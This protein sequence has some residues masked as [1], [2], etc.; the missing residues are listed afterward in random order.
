MKKFLATALLL[1]FCSPVV[2][3]EATFRRAE[4]FSDVHA[5]SCRVR[6]RSSLG[7][8]TFVGFTDGAGWIFTNYHVVGKETDVKLDFWTNSKL[9]TLEGKV[10]W[11]FYNVDLP[12]DFAFV[13]VDTNAL[14]R[15]DP[16]FVP[17][18]GPDV[19]PTKNG[20]I[21]SSGCPD[22]RFAQAWRGEVVSYYNGKT[23]VFQ[24]PPVPG[25]SGSGIVEYID[26]KPYVVAILTWLFGQKGSDE[27]TGGAIPV[28]N[29]YLAADG[30]V[31]L[32]MGTGGFDAI[33]PDATECTEKTPVLRGADEAG[34]LVIVVFKQLNC[35]YCVLYETELKEIEERGA[36]VVRI[37]RDTELGRTQFQ[38]W[39]VKTSPSTFVAAETKPAFYVRRKRLKDG[40]VPSGELEREL[41]IARDAIY[42]KALPLE[43]DVP[44]VAASFERDSNS[45]ES[46]DIVVINNDFEIAEIEDQE[47]E[48]EDFS[49]EPEI[50]EESSISEID[51]E[52]FRKR[53]PVHESGM[54]LG[55]LDKSKEDWKNR[56]SLPR[57]EETPLEEERPT[58]KAEKSKKDSDS[59]G[60]T[61]RL[62]DSIVDGALKSID[63]KLS[64]KQDEIRTQFELLQDKVL[65]SLFVL[66]IISFMTATIVLRVV[67]AVLRWIGRRVSPI[68]VAFRRAMENAW[69]ESSQNASSKKK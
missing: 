28:A 29:L 59:G 12:G 34:S 60:I 25:Q 31:R 9:E 35:D 10:C 13:K 14:K 38:Q 18:A 20:F 55:I 11:R 16:P 50:D 2:A 3:S 61:Q 69:Q 32:E 17:L 51:E 63:E 67:S 44:I 1:V 33:P 46:D 15:I 68:A 27:S 22:G 52:D 4:T 47:P 26:G 7:S 37:L 62:A 56:D 5:A 66:T 43:E 57:K 6:A 24:P 49:E 45:E 42:A 23:A 39:D 30:R 65:R 53:E 40:V 8:G 36:K 58:P 54:G 48:E 41:N 19:K 21:A 64:E